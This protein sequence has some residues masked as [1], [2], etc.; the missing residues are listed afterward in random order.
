M[1][2]F[3]LKLNLIQRY[4]I[5][6]FSLKLLRINSLSGQSGLTQ[7]CRVF[8]RLLTCSFYATFTNS[9]HLSVY[10]YRLDSAHSL[11]TI[12]CE[13]KSQIACTIFNF[14]LSMF[15]QLDLNGCQVCFVCYLPPKQSF[16]IMWVICS[17][18]AIITISSNHH[19]LM[20]ATDSFKSSKKCL[21]TTTNLQSFNKAVLTI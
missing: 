12:R 18:I 5:I 20:S 11:C 14:F 19:Q 10:T 16:Y 1:T 21:S 7:A 15:C 2:Y 9:F 8:Y 17:N 3:R 6:H 4:F 13:V